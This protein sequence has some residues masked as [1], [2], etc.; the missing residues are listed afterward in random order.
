MVFATGENQDKD[1]GLCQDLV[2]FGHWP[3]IPT[4]SGSSR[5]LA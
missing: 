3:I 4:F 1:L 2:D 5:I